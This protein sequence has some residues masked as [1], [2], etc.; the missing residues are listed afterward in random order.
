[1]VLAGALPVAAAVAPVAGVV[2]GPF[3]LEATASGG[4]GGYLYS[5]RQVAGPAAGLTGATAA[6]ATVVAFSPGSYAF[7]LTVT[8]SAGAVSAPTTVRV[9][10]TSASKPLPAANASA[11]ATA[12]V[13]EIVLLDGRAST[14]AAH[15]RWSQVAGPWVAIDPNSAT[16]IFQPPRAGTYSFELVVDDGTTRSAPASVTVTVE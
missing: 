9:D 12:V 11:P 1:V 8:D 5:W 3:T 13:S 15:Y 10:V 16:P 14:A 7:E 2:N 4:A 6:T